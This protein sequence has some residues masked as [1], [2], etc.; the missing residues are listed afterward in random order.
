MVRRPV[1]PEGNAVSDIFDEVN[2]ELRAERAQ[3][4][5]RR[6]GALLAGLALLAILGVGAYQGWKYYQTQQIGRQAQAFLAAMRIADGP[7]AQRQ[8]ALPDFAKLAQSGN[9]GYRTLSRLREAA[10][11]ANAGEAEL[12]NEG[13]ADTSAAPLLR[14]VANLQW[15]M[16]Q[17]ESGDPAAIATRLAPL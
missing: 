11:K 1:L 10:L 4:L 7:D 17:I 2:E 14:D 13:A 16:H 12:G 15:A 8:T 9:A 5:L 3:R 6:Y